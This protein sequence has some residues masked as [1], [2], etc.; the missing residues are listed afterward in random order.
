MVP[1]YQC[2]N[3]PSQNA[4]RQ[5]KPKPL[6]IVALIEASCKMRTLKTDGS[7]HLRRDIHFESVFTKQDTKLFAS[8]P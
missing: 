4:R 3:V 6:F 2:L 8:L 5:N 7:S 1:K